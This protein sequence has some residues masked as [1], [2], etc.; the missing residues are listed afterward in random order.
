[1]HY[2]ILVV[3]MQDCTILCRGIP[4]GAYLQVRPSFRARFGLSLRAQRSNLI[5][6]TLRPY[7]YPHVLFSDTFHRNQTG[8]CNHKI[9]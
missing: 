4:A 9:K 7:S 3:I 1:M 8:Y 6:G 5:V 2:Y